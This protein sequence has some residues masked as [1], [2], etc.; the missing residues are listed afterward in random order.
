MDCLQIF[1]SKITQPFPQKSPECAL[2]LTDLWN[3]SL[4]LDLI[5][6]FELIGAP[7]LALAKS[8]YY[9]ILVCQLDDFQRSF[10]ELHLVTLL[11]NFGEL[12]GIHVNL[13]DGG[14]ILRPNLL[15]S[16]ETLLS[17]PDIGISSHFR[18]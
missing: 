15:R 14:Q 12:F 18:I 10:K 11:M 2:K 6:K 9:W 16:R 7:L 5:Y 1:F 17:V 4:L 3:T 13:K 8:I